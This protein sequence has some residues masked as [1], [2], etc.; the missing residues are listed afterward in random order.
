VCEKDEQA[1]CPHEVSAEERLK[2]YIIEINQAVR[3]YNNYM[4]D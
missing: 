1:P 2:L 3:S 4:Y